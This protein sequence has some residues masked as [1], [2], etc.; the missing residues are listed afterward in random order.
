[1]IVQT[2]RGDFLDVMLTDEAERRERRLW[3]VSGLGMIAL[4][5][6]ALWVID[7]KEADRQQCVPAKYA[8]LL[9]PGGQA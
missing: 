3:I 1:M 8:A 7:R 6:A 2:K 5:V 4:T 9:L